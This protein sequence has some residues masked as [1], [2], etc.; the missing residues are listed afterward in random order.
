[1]SK[2]KH[3]KRILIISILDCRGTRRERKTQK[4]LSPHHPWIPVTATRMWSLRH[5]QCPQNPWT[6][7][8]LKRYWHAVLCRVSSHL[9]TTFFSL[10]LSL[11][12]CAIWRETIFGFFFAFFC[13]IL[14]RSKS[15]REMIILC[16]KLGLP[17]S[18]LKHWDCRKAKFAIKLTFLWF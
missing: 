10:S 1:M 9:I 5:R 7:W 6:L 17:S 11:S 16:S 18:P 3:H 2:I 4:S 8:T 12:R 14:S 15:K 13:I